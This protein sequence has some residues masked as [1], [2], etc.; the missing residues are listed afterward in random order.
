MI[1]LT[2]YAVQP[3]A[4][5]A[6]ECEKILCEQGGHPEATA[7]STCIF[8]FFVYDKRHVIQFEHPVFVPVNIGIDAQPEIELLFSATCHFHDTDADAGVVVLPGQEF[9]Q[10]GHGRGGDRDIHRLLLLSHLIPEGETAPGQA[11][12][13]RMPWASILS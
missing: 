10:P 7:G 1:L 6:K 2:E 9:A 8:L 4:W 3:E 13:A 11:R 12:T 5:L